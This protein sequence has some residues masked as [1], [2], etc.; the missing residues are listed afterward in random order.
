[1]ERPVIAVVGVCASGKTTLVR[2]LQELGYNAV[3]VAQEHSGVPYLWTKKNPDL[4]VLLD[5]R[6][7]TTKRRR[8]EIGYGP[9]RLEEQRH[10][11]RHAREHADLLLPTDELDVAAVRDRVV[12]LAEE[13]RQRSHG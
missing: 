10:R 5:A 3:N 8:P 1:M 13:W 6:W 12:A 11:L 7:E 4:V 2:G 9:E